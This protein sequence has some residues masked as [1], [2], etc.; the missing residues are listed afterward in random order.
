MNLEVWAD[1]IAHISYTVH[2]YIPAPIGTP[3]AVVEPSGFGSE[4]CSAAYNLCTEPIAFVLL[5]IVLRKQ[6]SV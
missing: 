6:V 5:Q 3:F 2:V 1:L 4:F